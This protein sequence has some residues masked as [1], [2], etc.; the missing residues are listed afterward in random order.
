MKYLDELYSI[1]E[2]VWNF[3]KCQRFNNKYTTLIDRFTFWYTEPKLQ[4]SAQRLVFP[5]IHLDESQVILL[6]KLL[7][8]SKI[9]IKE[10]SFSKS[11]WPFYHLYSIEQQNQAV[12]SNDPYSTE[13]KHQQENLF[14]ITRLLPATRIRIQTQILYLP[15]VCRTVGLSSMNTLTPLNIGFAQ[16]N[17]TKSKFSFY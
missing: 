9:K 14:R 8:S 16:V 3:I 15:S 10:F 5:I 1:V 13:Q 17:L 7:D 2:H 12:A 6:V 11:P 4:L